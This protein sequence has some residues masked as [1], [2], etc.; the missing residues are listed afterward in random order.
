MRFCI[1][2]FDI[3]YEK[4]GTGT[5]SII[6]LPGWGDTRPTFNKLINFL[7]EHFTVY[8]LDYPGFGNS[9]FP[10]R[11]LT[12]YDYADLINNFIQTNNITN[13]IA[14]GH[15]FGGRIITLLNTVHKTRFKKIILIDSAGIK[16]KKGFTK[17]IKQTIYKALKKITYILP[18]N[19]KTK[20]S[21]KLISIFGSTDFKTISPNIRKSFINIVNTD[22]TKQ[23]KNIKCDTLIL[24]GEN[25][26][27]TPL[28][29]AY[30]FNKL[31]NDSGLVIIKNSS[32]FPYLENPNYVH[33]IIFE[34]IKIFAT[35]KEVD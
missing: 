35:E 25:D 26:N 22:L 30:K 23:I 17:L 8:I 18:S 1:N 24:W 4:Y 33:R 2:D 29:D 10:N 32:H 19:L 14:I 34:F 3:Y 7:K 13:P 9:P 21:N 16:P 6:I 5:T 28:K 31:I 12:I 27:D 11:D 15:S 20:Y